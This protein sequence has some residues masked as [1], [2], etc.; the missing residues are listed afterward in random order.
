MY[1]LTVSQ[2]PRLNGTFNASDQIY[3]SCLII[4]VFASQQIYCCCLIISVFFGSYHSFQKKISS[5]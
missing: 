3:C 2:Q 4:S 5:F 1:V